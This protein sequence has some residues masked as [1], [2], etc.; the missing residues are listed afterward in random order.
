[1]SEKTLRLCR[2]LFL[3][4]LTS[5]CQEDVSQN[6]GTGTPDELRSTANAIAPKEPTAQDWARFASHMEMTSQRPATHADSMRITALGDS[7]RR[8]IEKYRD[9]RVVRAAGYEPLVPDREFDEKHFSRYDL[10]SKRLTLRIDDPPSL[11]YRKDSSNRFILVGA[12]YVVPGDYSQAALD[13]LVPLSLAR[14]HKH[15]NWCI[16]R[17]NRQEDWTRRS[18]GNLIFG[19]FGVDDRKSCSANNGVFK[20]DL[21]GWMVHALVFAGSDLKSVWGGE[22]M[23]GAVQAH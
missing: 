14:W 4:C 19:V 8:V 17:L 12:M 22:M 7:I 16:P 1:M 3:I 5:A 11:L 9:V 18:N 6:E 10:A 2:I 21:A 15:I 20:P 23:G 13:S